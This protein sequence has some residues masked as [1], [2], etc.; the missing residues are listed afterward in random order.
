MAKDGKLL[1]V[2]VAVVAL[3]APVIQKLEVFQLPQDQLQLPEG[4]LAS[5]PAQ[6]PPHP[7]QLAAVLAGKVRLLQQ[8]PQQVRTTAF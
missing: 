1:E 3:L 6:G 2:G 5:H 7:G 8:V 4:R